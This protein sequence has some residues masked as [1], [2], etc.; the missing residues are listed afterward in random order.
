MNE[1]RKG[2]KERKGGRKESRRVG[3][4]KGREQ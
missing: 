4:E 1:D 2:L 3:K